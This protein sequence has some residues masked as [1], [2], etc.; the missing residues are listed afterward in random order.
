M[1]EQDVSNIFSNV[2]Q[3][4]SDGQVAFSSCWLSE[5]VP[6]CR[7]GKSLSTAGTCNIWVLRPTWNCSPNIFMHPENSLSS[8]HRVFQLEPL[9][10]RQPR[11]LPPS[12]LPTAEAS[13]H[14]RLPDQTAPISNFNHLL[15]FGVVVLLAEK[16]DDLVEFDQLLQ[17]QLFIFPAWETGVSGIS[18]FGLELFSLIV[19]RNIWSISG[20]IHYWE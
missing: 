8:C 16:P 4:P 18:M 9:I 12:T 6:G 1:K 14:A 19:Q 15:R 17:S 13:L 7:L 3:S 11:C 20:I 10:V 2:T 5:D